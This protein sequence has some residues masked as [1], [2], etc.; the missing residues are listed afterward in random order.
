MYKIYKIINKIDDKIYVGQS[1]NP[2][3]RFRDHLNEAKNKPK[4]QCTYL[5]NA[6]NFHGPENFVLEIIEEV[7]LELVNEREIYWILELKSK[8]PNGYNLNDGGTGQRNPSQ[9]TRDKMSLSQKDKPKSEETKKNM[10]VAALNRSDANKQAHIERL[11]IMNENKVYDD[12]YRA[13]LSASNAHRKLEHED[14]AKIVNMYNKIIRQKN[15]SQ[16]VAKEFGISTCTV[17]RIVNENWRPKG[18]NLDLDKLI[19]KI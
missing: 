2:R 17:S 16:Q 11:R 10:S 15:R 8:S 12:E 19:I 18:Y 9:E 14:Y 5:N 13:K 4:N 7:S 6:I 3:R 1:D